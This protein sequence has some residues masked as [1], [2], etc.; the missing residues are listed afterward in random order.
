MSVV[1]VLFVSIFSLVGLLMILKNRMTEFCVFW[2]LVASA[3]DSSGIVNYIDSNFGL[4]TAIMNVELLF[5]LFLSLNNY[6]KKRDK[7]YESWINLILI[8]A[9]FS[10]ISF[11]IA[12]VK[13]LAIHNVLSII[14]SSVPFCLIIFLCDEKKY[15]DRKKDFFYAIKLFVYI[16]IILCFLITYLPTIGINIL[17][18]M[19]ASNYISDGYIYNRNLFHLNDIY[20]AL[21]TK[22]I[23][24]GLGHFHN[25]NDMGFYGIVGILIA[26]ESFRRNKNLFR[27]IIDVFVVIMSLMLWGNSGMR[28]PVIGVIIGV[29]A[30]AIMTNKIQIKIPALILLIC[31]L[32]LLMF[33]EAGHSILYYFIPDSSNISV[34]SRSIL[35]RNGLEYIASNPFFGAGGDIARLSSQEIDPHELPLRMACLYGI[36]TAILFVILIYIKPGFLIL[37]KKKRL[38]I[39]V[40]FGIIGGVT[41]TNNYTD[42]GLFQFM[43]AFIVIKTNEGMSVNINEK[44]SNFY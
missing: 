23:F 26:I 5:C 32:G 36:P 21:T 24:N 40:F 29:I 31:G 4:Y 3:T 2:I 27:K 11:L 20:Q 44:S 12:G 22:Y 17:D 19:K 34:S 30:Y 43:M 33:S 18:F 28:G 42:F 39:L 9:C 13:N 25:G 8:I 7:M 38:L 15:K 37:K 35:R 16:Q 10:I 6:C 41:L 1:A 14:C